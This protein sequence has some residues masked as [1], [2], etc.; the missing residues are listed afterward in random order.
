MDELQGVLTAFFRRSFFSESIG[1][2]GLGPLV[3]P[4]QRPETMA[5]NVKR[6]GKSG[7]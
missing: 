1:S 5:I 3:H 6:I 4:G 7:V 2:K